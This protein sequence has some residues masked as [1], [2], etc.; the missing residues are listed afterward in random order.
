MLAANSNCVISFFAGAEIKANVTY[1]ST[2][3][4]SSRALEEVDYREISSCSIAS[5]RAMR[6]AETVLSQDTE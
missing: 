4:D 6:D 1:G 3:A 2:L 5:Y